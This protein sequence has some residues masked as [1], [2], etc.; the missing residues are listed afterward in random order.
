VANPGPE[1][2]EGEVAVGRRIRSLRIRVDLAVL[3][4]LVLA[5]PPLVAA[6]RVQADVPITSRYI[7]SDAA[8]ANAA[9]AFADV[10]AVG[11]VV[12]ENLDAADAVLAELTSAQITS[13]EQVPTVTVTPDAVVS[14]SSAAGSLGQPS[15]VFPQQ[16]GAT[17][18]WAQGDSGAG[19]NVAVVDTGIDPLPDFG[20]LL[21]G[22]DLSGE[23]NPELDSYGHGTFVAGL[24]AGNGAT[25][26]GLYKG[27]APGAG[28]VPVKVAG[29][30]GQT[31]LA[32][33]IAGVGWVIAHQNSEHIGVINLSLGAI[34]TESSLLNPLDEAVQRAWQ[35]GIVVVVAA[36]NDGPFNGTILAPA[37]DPLVIS[38]GAVDDH[39]S[40][41]TTADTMSDFS[42][43]GPTSPDGWIKP[44][45]VSSGQSVVS[46]RA[47]GS[48]IDTQNPSAR[49]GTGN[50]VGSG[51][52]FSAAVTSGAAALLLADH[53][54]DRPNDVKASLLGTASPGPVGNPLVDGHGILD[55]AAAA[56]ASGLH[57]TQQ[58]GQ[59]DVTQASFGT[60]AAISP[61]APVAV[62]YSLQVPGSHPTTTLE[63]LGGQLDVPI[64]CAPNAAVAGFVS[65]VVPANAYQ[66]AANAGG[67]VPPSAGGT[68]NLQTTGSAP[69]LCNG[70][71]MYP[72]TSGN[73][74]V[75]F[76][77][78]VVSTA[79]TTPANIH[80][81]Y[82]LGAK[83][84]GVS[85]NASVTPVAM[86]QGGVGV[87]LGTTW[88]ESTWNGSHW[89]GVHWSAETWTSAGWNP[90]AWDGTSW[91]G[92]AWNLGAWDGSHWSG[93]HW[94]GS[95]WSGT[96]WDG[97]HWSGSAWS[98][99]HWSGAHWSGGSWGTDLTAEWLA[100]AAPVSSA[101]PY[102]GFQLVSTS[103]DLWCPVGEALGHP[104]NVGN[105]STPNGG[106]PGA[107]GP[108][109]CGS[110]G[111]NG[112]AGGH[113]DAQ[114]G[115]GGA[116]GDGGAG[117]CP[118]STDAQMAAGQFPCIGSGANGGSGGNGG[119]S[120][121][122]VAGGPGGAGGAGGDAQGAQ[123][124]AGGAGGNAQGSTPGGAG[125][126]GGAGGGCVL[127]DA[128]YW[129]S[130]PSAGGKGGGGGQGGA[131]GSGGNGAPGGAAGSS[132]STNGGNGGSGGN[133]G[134]GRNGTPGQAGSAG[135]SVSG[136]AG[137]NGVNGQNG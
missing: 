18:L 92:S 45:L 109:G 115:I 69:D 83:V 26:G 124:G 22:V 21:P 66:L 31:D 58:A 34:P 8:G 15:A 14:M 90:S 47:P 40:L 112:G 35:S 23:G 97:S 117:G 127:Y 103:P 110:N 121:N 51:T 99:A 81:S 64:A 57:L 2:S 75:Q 113:G 100:A 79:T 20:R 136:A 78:S 62:G 105:T 50:F 33:V 128:S 52:S 70:G 59:V 73:T 65:L 102:P 130:C 44:D 119:D 77:G 95:H 87:D 63:L 19:V 38:V 28:L 24:I 98:G 89:S 111:G 36:G 132:S 9:V 29:A 30:S 101:S 48:T 118:A 16:S 80:F 94:S 27:E 133:G 85:P 67:W 55:V 129:V 1:T 93:A 108:P 125:G 56:S 122:G 41:S 131:G 32:T 53:P 68:T 114:G 72:S 3:A 17:H 10:S 60:D 39:G 137:S 104:G 120:H 86:T 46:L 37:D 7:V 13:L 88:S 116:G 43:A 71:L 135:G 84:S 91:N 42:A 82:A 6:S 106:A 4:A 96:A 25:S 123:G 76:S 126:V 12:D 49:I 134:N 107:G 61:G 54:S 11:G 5:A 74:P